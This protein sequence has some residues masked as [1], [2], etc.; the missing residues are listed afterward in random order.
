MAALIMDGVLAV[1]L[2][3]KRVVLLTMAVA[4]AAVL[5]GE[6]G[7]A[8]IMVVFAAQVHIGEEIV[9]ALIMD[10]RDA[11]QKVSKLEK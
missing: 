1:V 10:G 9:A 3:E 7:E 8:L 6:K 4:L 2:I 11:D 5:I